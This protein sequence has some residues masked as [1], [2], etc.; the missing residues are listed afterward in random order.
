MANSY[1]QLKYEVDE[2]PD[3]KTTLILAIQHISMVY[4]GI[5]LMPIIIGRAVGLDASTI[6]YMVFVTVITSAI[7]TYIQIYKIGKIGSG[8]VMFMGSSGAYWGATSTA[9]AV[10]GIPLLMTMN[11][12]S[13][14]LEIIA[15][16]FLVPL[17][18]IFTPAVGG[19][20]IMLIPV[21]V[22]P[23]ILSAYSGEIKASGQV[24]ENIIIA[25][26][27]MSV[28]LGCYI[29][30]PKKYQTLMVLA[31]LIVGSVLATALGIM[32]WQS[33]AGASIIGLPEMKW[34]LPAFDFTW[35]HFAIL[36]S[37]VIA[38]LS[39]TIETIG[40]TM[41]CESISYRKFVKHDFS[42]ISGALYADGIGNI[43]SG[44]TGGVANTTY[45]TNIPLIKITQVS[46]RIVGGVGATILLMLAFSPV[47]SAIFLIIPNAVLVPIIAFTFALLFEAGLSLAGK[48][49]DRLSQLIVGFSFL[50]GVAG[51]QKLLLNEYMPAV[52]QEI[53]GNALTTGGLIAII[54]SII[55]NMVLKGKVVLHVKTL[56]TNMA[57][58]LDELENKTQA[59]FSLSA[60]DSFRL[61]LC[62]EELF[63]FLTEHNI[64]GN[65]TAKF[66]VYRLPNDILTCDVITAFDVNDADIL[67]ENAEIGEQLN[68]VI[69]NK[70][71]NKVEHVR[72]ESAGYIT[73]ELAPEE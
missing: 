54:L 4:S 27:T 38:T 66:S 47:I 16:K 1:N 46:S 59:R 25:I 17:R 67:T 35:Q 12:I 48:N 29:F 2:K 56:K 18:K 21:S 5:V 40:D 9:L 3:F 28:L 6:S 41:V 58:F 33:V 19:T 60:R 14:F 20:V 49:S 32:D 45:S 64:D 26:T 10:G 68:L 72:S 61:R 22:L 13:A 37:F 73:F 55:A 63:D 24:S 31:G 62:A 44:L 36:L 50:I 42:K 71:A 70:L 23:A 15:A 39:S 53:F 11:I 7:A 52:F 34:Q 43:L 30:A 69:L 57:E 51:G 8:M 65:L